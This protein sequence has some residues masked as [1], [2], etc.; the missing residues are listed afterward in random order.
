MVVSH[1]AQRRLDL[2]DPQSAA[3]VARGRALDNHVQPTNSQTDL[4]RLDLNRTIAKMTPANRTLTLLWLEGLSAVHVEHVTGVKAGTVAVRAQPH[5][6]TTHSCR[7]KGMNDDAVRAVW[8]SVHASG[9]PRSR[10]RRR[11][12]RSFAKSVWPTN[13]S[14]GSEFCWRRRVDRALSR[15]CF[16]AA[17]HGRTPLDSVAR[18]GLMAIGV[19]VLV[20]AEWLWLRWSRQGWPGPA[21][22][23][24]QLRTAVFVLA[25]QA[26]YPSRWRCCGVRRS[27][28]APGII[29][30]SIAR[31]RSLTGGVALGVAT[32]LAWAVAA[33]S[34]YAKG[35]AIDEQQPRLEQV[36]R[37]LSATM[38]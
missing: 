25:R 23:R 2:A 38:S 14:D 12:N 37:N 7:G 15:S 9:E 20:A 17:A 6:K 26:K 4:R 5:S 10:A 22:T 29:A 21:D 3:A 16:W 19:S 36:L 33:A 35:R 34:C 24:A 31:A 11:S 30:F 1:R 18:T 13:K 28:S 27:S 32:G 8:L